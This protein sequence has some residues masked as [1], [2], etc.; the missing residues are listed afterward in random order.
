[1]GIPT[2]ILPE[3]EI[4]F[5]EHTHSHARMNE[6]GIETDEAWNNSTFKCRMGQDVRIPIVSSTS[7]GA[8][9]M[10]KIRVSNPIDLA[11]GCDQEYLTG[12]LPSGESALSA[13]PKYYLTVEG[14]FGG[15]ITDLSLIHI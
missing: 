13:R 6:D 1:M 11:V 15:D 9:S 10:V 4:L 2:S 5:G 12:V 8:C 14:S 7:G 3:K